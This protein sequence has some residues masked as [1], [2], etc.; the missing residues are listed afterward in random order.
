M[1]WIQKHD[2]DGDG[3]RHLIVIS[4]LH[5]RIVKLAAVLPVARLPRIGA[6]I[7]AVGW[8]SVGA[9]G[10]TELDAQRYASGGRT[11]LHP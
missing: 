6:R 9:S 4:R 11:A 3:D 7:D 1:I 5:P 8:L 10:H 2:P